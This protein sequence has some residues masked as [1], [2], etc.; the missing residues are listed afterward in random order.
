[1]RTVCRNF[2]PVKA[3]KETIFRAEDLEEDCCGMK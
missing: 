1:M 2:K 3:E